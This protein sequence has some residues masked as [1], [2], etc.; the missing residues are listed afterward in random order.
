MT[1]VIGVASNITFELYF[2][3][4]HRYIISQIKDGG[5]GVAMRDDLQSQK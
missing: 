2:G 1:L 3:V 4:K 5:A